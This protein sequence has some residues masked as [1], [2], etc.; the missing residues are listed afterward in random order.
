MFDDLRDNDKQGA[1]FYTDDLALDPD[2]KKAKARK[3]GG[4]FLGLT[5]FQRMVLS[6]LLM[7]AACLGGVMLLVLTNKMVPF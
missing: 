2:A 1:S 3:G 4:K 7:V 5:A 6:L